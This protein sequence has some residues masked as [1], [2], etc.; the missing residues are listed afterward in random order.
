MPKTILCKEKHGALKTLLWG[1]VKQ[2]NAPLEEGARKLGMSASTL[3]RRCTN[4]GTMTVDELLNFGMKYHV[5]IEEIR[6]AL[7]Y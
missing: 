6:S 5:P 3:S 1:T 7:R 4:P 2:D